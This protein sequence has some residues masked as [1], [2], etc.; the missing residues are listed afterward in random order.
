MQSS[1][2]QK[3]KG[4]DSKSK[5]ADSKSK[6]TDSKS[7]GT[8]KSSSSGKPKSR[9]AGK[10]EGFVAESYDPPPKHQASEQQMMAAEPDET[11]QPVDPGYGYR[12][13]VDPG[14]GHPYADAASFEAAHQK[15][16]YPSMLPLAPLF[17]NDA[18]SPGGGGAS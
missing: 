14:Q 13:E 1:G 18:D 5:G 10:E 9:K 2:S 17:S 3:S 4:K 7:K 12:T 15:G 16:H 6:G 11:V 8:G